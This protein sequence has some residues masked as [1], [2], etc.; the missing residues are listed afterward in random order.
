MI[1]FLKQLNESPEEANCLVIAWFHFTQ[2]EF[3]QI[4][5]RRV[6]WNFACEKWREKILKEKN[7]EES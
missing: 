5:F 4:Q 3:F 7:K 6:C 2:G 1:V